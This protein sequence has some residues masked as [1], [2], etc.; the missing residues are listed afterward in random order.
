MLS[1][2][3]FRLKTFSTLPY[4]VLFM[5]FVRE[6]FKGILVHSRTLLVFCY[7]YGRFSKEF[8]LTSVLYLCFA[9][10]TGGFSKELF[11]KTCIKAMSFLSRQFYCSSSF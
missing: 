11:H 7:S 4:F 1:F 2:A 3:K 8:L 9:V 10:R 6:F 5:L